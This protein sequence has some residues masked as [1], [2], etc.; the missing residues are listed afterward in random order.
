MKELILMTDIEKTIFNNYFKHV[1]RIKLLQ[2]DAKNMR[3]NALK[4]SHEARL[5]LI[6]QDETVKALNNL[7]LLNLKS[8]FQR[9]MKRMKS[10]IVSQGVMQRFPSVLNYN[11]AEGASMAYK[12]LKDVL[13]ELEI[14][15]TKKERVFVHS[16][17]SE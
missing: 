17:E 3:E 12:D 16:N 15:E 2:L 10:D 9:V 1:A 6:K 7:D 13:I 14:I 4:N 5:M 8:D 11:F